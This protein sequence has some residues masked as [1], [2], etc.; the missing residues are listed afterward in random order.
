MSGTDDQDEDDLRA[1]EY[2]LGLL[3]IDEAQRLRRKAELRPELAAAITRWEVYLAPLLAQVP[4]VN[5]PAAL[6][7]RIEASAFGSPAAMAGGG[8]I[9]AWHSLRLWRAA[10]ITL[11]LAAGIAGFALLRRPAELPVPVAALLPTEH[12]GPAIVASALPDGRLALR[13]IG[14]LSVPA[15]HDLELWSLPAG[16][17][18]PVSLGVMQSGG[19]VLAAD[20]APHG[21]GKILVSLEPRGGSPTGL[22]TGPVLW[23]GILQ[24]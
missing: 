20:R 6:W 13:P 16:A 19:M 4:P 17:T 24:P 1:G 22:P 12:Q 5:P 8:A 15:G 14:Q 3:D 21:A 2:V 18:R 9:N 10:A 7:T 23:G 11:A